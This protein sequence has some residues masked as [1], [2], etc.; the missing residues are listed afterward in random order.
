MSMCGYDGLALKVFK[1]SYFITWWQLV[2]HFYP[3]CFIL[4][5]SF[6]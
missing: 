6:R 5:A 1:I 3:V 2:S 4:H